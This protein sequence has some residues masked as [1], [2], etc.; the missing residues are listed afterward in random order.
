M[1]PG[2]ADDDATDVTTRARSAA[3]DIAI[4]TELRPGDVGAI[5]HLH[6]LLYAAEYG[7]DYTFE[8]YVAEALARFALAHDPARERLWTVERGDRLLG[9]LAMVGAEPHVAQLR[10]FLLSPELRGRG[11]GK[12]L[13]AD[14]LDFCHAAGY[15]SVFLWTVRG[16]EPA[17]ALYRA[18]G[19]TLTREERHLRWGAQVVEERL[20]LR[21]G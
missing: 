11:L 15:E 18:A 17:G 6:G 14:A 8:A 9:C 20:D 16:L 21:L 7:W 5:V 2:S 3:E 10:W 19:F 4:R 1:G 13:L 12:R